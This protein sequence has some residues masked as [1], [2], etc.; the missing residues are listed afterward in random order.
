MKQ[1]TRKTELTFP[2]L[3]LLWSFT[4]TLQHRL[5]RVNSTS[6]VLICDCNEEDIKRA[7]ESFHAILPQ[8]IQEVA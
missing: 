3:N 7:I 4:S 5:Y 2:D 6:R 8:A 1:A